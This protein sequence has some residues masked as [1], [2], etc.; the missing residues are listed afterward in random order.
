MTHVIAME[1][2]AKHSKK[3]DCAQ[4]SSKLLEFTEQTCLE[5]LRELSDFVHRTELEHARALRDV[6][7]RLEIL[8]VIVAGQLHSLEKVFRENTATFERLSK[9]LG[10]R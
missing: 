7:A 9:H 3:C 1:K 6:C 10:V 8:E 5:K 4:C 2:P